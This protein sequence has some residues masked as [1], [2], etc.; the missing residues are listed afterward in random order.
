[1]VADEAE[2]T[3]RLADELMGL[4]G[5]G[6]QRE[7]VPGLGMAEAYAVAERLRALREARGE[8]PIGRKIGFTNKTIWERYGV[9]APMWSYVYDRTVRWAEAGGARVAFAGMP[10]P[11]VE[12]E[13]V[14]GIGRAP[15]PDMDETALLSCV[16]WVAQGFEIVQSVYPGWRMTGPEAAAAY[17]LHGALAIGPRRAVGADRAGRAAALRRF[18]VELRC[19]SEIR[20]RGAAS[21]VLGGPV[22]ALR[23]LVAEIARHPGATPLAAGEIVT[24]G[25]LTDAH[26]A[27]PGE[28]WSAAFAGIDLPGFALSLVDAA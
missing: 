19:G 15:A 10:E 23:F 26:P 13:V 2:R 1:V 11:R 21:N 27:A 17:G 5:T 12:P 22:S 6:G 3:E 14:L 8:R 16:D 7:G 20:D 18:T 9:D 28:V 24:T 4:L 25:T